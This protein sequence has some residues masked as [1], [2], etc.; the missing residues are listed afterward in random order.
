MVHFEIDVK[1]EALPRLMEM[2]GSL[3]AGD[4]ELHDPE[5]EMES[6]LSGSLYREQREKV[7][8]TKQRLENGEAALFTADEVLE[9]LARREKHRAS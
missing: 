3:E 7:L 8:Q 4:V 5:R 9:R 6:Y 1:E 2:L